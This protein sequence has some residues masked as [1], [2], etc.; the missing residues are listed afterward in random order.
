VS[1][2]AHHLESEG[3]ATTLI[4][5]IRLHAEKARPPRALWVPFQL[6]RPVGAPLNKA[7]QHRVLSIALSLLEKDAATPILED[8]PEDEPNSQDTKNWQAPFMFQSDGI[9]KEV[10]V[11]RDYFLRAQART[12]RSTFGI[13][14]ISIEAVVDYLLALDSGTPLRNPRSD[15]TGAQMLRYAV[16]DLKIYYLEALTEADISPSSWQA[17][18]W[19]WEQTSAG[20]VVKQLRITS[21]THPDKNRRLASWW[22]VPDGW[23]DAQTVVKMR[24]IKHG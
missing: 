18:N 11:L 10:R 23:S 14:G 7:F 3:I 20:A 9:K 19:F 24:R 15:L 4:A 5:L 13:S 21:L 6:G 2:I 16:D 12:K 1:A 22:L 8:F 17:A